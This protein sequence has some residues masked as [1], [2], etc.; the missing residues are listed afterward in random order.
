MIEIVYVY[1]VIYGLGLL[2]FDAQ[3]NSKI[4]PDKKW[5]LTKC[6]KMITN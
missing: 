2:N 4:I 5:P 1:N 3:N 6:Q